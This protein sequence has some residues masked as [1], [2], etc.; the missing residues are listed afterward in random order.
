MKTEHLFSKLRTGVGGIL[1]FFCSCSLP[2]VESFLL[3]EKG[4]PSAVFEKTPGGEKSFAFFNETL[5]KMG[6]KPFPVVAEN[7]VPAG[8]NVKEKKSFLRL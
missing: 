3:W 6:K 2:G 5:R 8:K 1:L 7:A 4:S